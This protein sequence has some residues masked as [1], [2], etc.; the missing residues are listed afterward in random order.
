MAS[1][2]S[3]PLGEKFNHD[4]HEAMFEVPDTGQPNGTI[5]HLLEP[6]YVL[7]GRLLRAARVG[8]AKDK[9]TDADEHVVD[10]TA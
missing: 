10:T 4:F 2:G 3:R 8:V 6:G 5:V 7:R 1:S 9:A